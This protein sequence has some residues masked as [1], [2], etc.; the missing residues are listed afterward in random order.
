M[1]EARQFGRQGCFEFSLGR[2]GIGFSDP[3]GN[4]RL[5]KVGVG[6]ADNGRLAYTFDTVQAQLDLSVTRIDVNDLNTAE[7][8]WEEEDGDEPGTR[9][10]PVVSIDPTPSGATTEPVIE[11]VTRPAP[12]GPPPAADTVRRGSGAAPAP[13]PVPEAADWGTPPG[14]PAL[15]TTLHRP[16]AAE[17]DQAQS[18]SET[19][20]P[21]RRWWGFV[22]AAVVLVLAGVG[23]VAFTGGKAPESSDPATTAAEVDPLDV[24][25]G[26]VPAAAD[27]AGEES[28][29]DVVFT[30]SNPEPADGDTYLWRLLDPLGESQYT[31]TTE[32]T[33]T[34]AADSGGRTCLEVL[35]RRSGKT[36]FEPARACV[37]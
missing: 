34:V 25:G 9:I 26:V 35:I 18:E 31:E 8:A 14:A 12:S 27:L 24:V 10:R 1:L 23:V 19:P 7:P 28:G 22:A 17:P 5:S 3:D 37:P 20:A 13:A 4:H 29:D 2:S 15:D 11:P 36:S 30:W 32:T 21:R 6:H 16:S 33:A